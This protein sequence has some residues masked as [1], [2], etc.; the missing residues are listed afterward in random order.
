MVCSVRKSRLTKWL[1]Y[2]ALLIAFK[3]QANTHLEI[4]VIVSVPPPCIVNNNRPIEVN[5]GDAVMTTRL[6]GNH[7][8]TPIDYKLTCGGQKSN[9]MRLR[10]RGNNADFNNQL[11]ATDKSGLGIALLNNGVSTQVNSLFNFTYP[12]LPVL[13]AVPV[14]QDGVALTAGKFTAAATLEVFYQ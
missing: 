3:G 6:D 2:L 12:N 5:F 4:K 10:L 9:A 13:E 11:L 7:Y 8:R 14:K 1:G